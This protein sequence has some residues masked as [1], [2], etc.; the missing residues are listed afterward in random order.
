MEFS[1]TPATFC[2]IEIKK[3]K[4]GNELHETLALAFQVKFFRHPLFVSPVRLATF[5]AVV[6]TVAGYHAFK[7]SCKVC[8]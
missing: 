2:N 4:K 5:A 6:P 8:S 7:P 1:A 3:K